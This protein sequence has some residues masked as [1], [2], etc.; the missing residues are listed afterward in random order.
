[1]TLC[2]SVATPEL[3]LCASTTRVSWQDATTG[4]WVDVRDDRLA[5]FSNVRRVGG[6]W[7]RGGWVTGGGS[8][9]RWFPKVYALAQKRC[10]GR[11]RRSCAC[12]GPRSTLRI[13]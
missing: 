10:A 2:I 11:P 13:G 4:E 7:T 5:E 8:D 9:V 3:A 12:V 1:M 6:G